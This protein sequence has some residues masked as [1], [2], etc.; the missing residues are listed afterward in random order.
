MRL[1]VDLNSV[2]GDKYRVAT[3]VA[4]IIRPFV[5]DGSSELIPHNITL[6][7]VA[8][9]TRMNPHIVAG[10]IDAKQ[11]LVEGQSVYGYIVFSDLDG[12]TWSIRQGVPKPHTR[13]KKAAKMAGHRGVNEGGLAAK[14]TF[15]N[16]SRRFEFESRNIVLGIGPPISGLRNEFVRPTSQRWTNAAREKM[17]DEIISTAKTLFKQWQQLLND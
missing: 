11:R 6:K 9:V 5:L 3:A 12:H 13:I 14:R 10:I 8:R 16:M 1:E 2:D 7:E 4:D 15:E 17:Q